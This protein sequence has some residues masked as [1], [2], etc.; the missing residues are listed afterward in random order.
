MSATAATGV[1]AALAKLADKAPYIEKLGASAIAAKKTKPEKA[2]GQ[3]A[4]DMRRAASG[5]AGYDQSA[6]QEEITRARG[7]VQRQIADR[8]SK[9]A[10]GSAT[11][12]GSSGVSQGDQLATLGQ[13]QEAYRQAESDV[14]AAGLKDAAAKRDLALQAT[15]KE[16]EMAAA[17]KD[18]ALSYAT[19]G[20]SPDAAAAAGGK[21]RS[22]L[23]SDLKNLFGAL[24]KES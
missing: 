15:L 3:Y 16:A 13:G 9:L 14:R 24:A 8:M 11:T 20:L 4:E 17:R 7:G 23:A 22:G 12:T 18:A 10:R 1:A 21:A 6:Y 19:T 2:L 5:G